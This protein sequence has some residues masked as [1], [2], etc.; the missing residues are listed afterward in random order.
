MLLA[1]LGKFNSKTIKRITIHTVCYRLWKSVLSPGDG[2]TLYSLQALRIYSIR[3]LLNVIFSSKSFASEYYNPELL[4][5]KH[6]ETSMQQIWYLISVTRT[7][8]FTTL[9]R[10]NKG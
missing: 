10:E 5:L 1:V 7:R 3:K 4:L 2:V 6:I 9:E 8:P